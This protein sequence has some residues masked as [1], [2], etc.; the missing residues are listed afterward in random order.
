[1]LNFTQ[2]L[3]RDVISWTWLEQ[4]RQDFWFAA[5]ALL[6]RPGFAM[7][8]IATLALGIG[9]TTAIFSVAD[10]VL[11]RPLPYPQS[12]QLVVVR[13]ELSKMGVHYNDVSYET[14]D[15]YRKAWCFDATA[16]FTEEDGTL[17]GLGSADRVSVLSS[18]ASLPGMLGAR[19]IAGRMFGKQDWNPAHNDVA[20]LSQSFYASRFGSSNSAIGRTI[21]LDDRLYKVIGVTAPEFKFGISGKSA[22]VW[23][24]LPTLRDP[25]VWQFRMLARMRPGIDIAQ[26]QAEITQTAKHIEETVRPYRGPHNEDGGYSARVFTLREQVFGEFRSGSLLLTAASALLLLI[27]CVNV[28]NLL[29]ARAATREKETAMRRALGASRARLLQQWMTEASVLAILGG[30]SGLVVSRWGVLLLERLGPSDMPFASGIGTDGRVLLFTLMTSVLVCLLLSLAPVVASFD[31]NLSLRGPQRRR[32]TANWLVTADVSIAIVLLIGCSLLG[33]SLM[34]LRQI[35][36]GV[37]VDHLLTMKTQLSGDRYREPRRR[38]EF[39]SEAVARLSRLPGVVSVSDVDRLPIYQVGADT[40]YGNPFSLDG[41]PWNPGAQT[42]QMAHTNTVGIGYFRTMGIALINGRDFAASDGI[43]GS[44]VAIVNQTLARTFFPKRNAV[45]Q[46]ILFGAPEPGNH[47]M[48][49]VGVV[50]DVR[51]GALDLPAPP[52]FFMPETQAANNSMVIVLRTGGNPAAMSRAA[53]GVVREL[54]PE[55]PIS[56]VSTMEEHVEQT[57]GQ[58]RFRTVLTSLFGLMALVLAAV[59]IFGVVSNSVTQ[60]TKELGIRSALGADSARIAATVLGDGMRPVALGVVLGVGGGAMLSRLLAS[61]LYEVKAGDLTTL[62]FAIVV[63]GIVA[64]AAC[65]AP[66]LTAAR[67]DPVIALRQ[68]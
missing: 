14:F 53:V 7:T 11:L 13:D 62:A 50:S 43:R 10:F 22:D 33:K 59:G 65:L 37:R 25:Q 46:R 57:M 19:T 8:A 61:I 12:G 40:R 26:A 58:P 6:K 55:Q 18:T 5:R 44:D 42:R 35:D 54:D 15:G 32:S 56:D 66:A 4:V 23:I 1:M 38:V 20:I 17:T 49:I 41:R 45:G 30:V 28:A 29:L 31:G 16:A 51:N 24:P 34:A 52:Q 21:H 60:R 67:I 68:E 48:T 47:W 63:I 2:K 9:A 3:Q 64:A 36:P 39:F 27:A